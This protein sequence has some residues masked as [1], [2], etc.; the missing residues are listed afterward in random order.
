[1]ARFAPSTRHKNEGVG[2][3]VRCCSPLGRKS[4]PVNGLDAPSRQSARGHGVLVT[5]LL[6]SLINDKSP[7]SNF[8]GH[9]ELPYLSSKSTKTISR[10][11]SGLPL[12]IPCREISP[13]LFGILRVPSVSCQLRP[14]KPCQEPNF[15]A[16]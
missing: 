15:Q 16:I 11:V 13:S 14:F 10:S 9:Q 2:V 7:E 4:E 3:G 8:D 6:L 1:M 12:P 5:G